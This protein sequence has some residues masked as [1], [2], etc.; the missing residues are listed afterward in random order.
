[1]HIL[2]IFTSFVKYIVEYY[3]PSDSDVCKDGELQ[4]W[5]NEIFTHGFLG[6]KL[7]GK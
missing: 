3:Y 1:M 4:E 5:I 6:N 2:Y 7:S